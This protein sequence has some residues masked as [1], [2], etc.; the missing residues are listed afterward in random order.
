MA[1]LEGIAGLRPVILR[2]TNLCGV[3]H[4]SRFY[5]YSRMTRLVREQAAALEGGLVLGGA[6]F[7]TSRTDS[8][9]QCAK[10]AQYRAPRGRAISV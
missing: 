2:M 8:E 3:L 9:L 7:V 6:Y 4:S 10:A 1:E 5:C